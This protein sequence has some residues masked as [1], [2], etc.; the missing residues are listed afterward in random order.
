MEARIGLELRGKKPSEV[1]EL[2]LDN[3]K[4]SKI[5]GLTD[6]YTSLNT[7]SLINVGR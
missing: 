2:L 3:C 1:K 6:E 7:I 5:S 4:A